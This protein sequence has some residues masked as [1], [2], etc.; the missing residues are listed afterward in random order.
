MHSSG[1]WIRDWKARHRARF[2]FAQCVVQGL[3]LRHMILALLWPAGKWATGLLDITTWYHHVVSS[4]GITTWCLLLGT[5][6]AVLFAIDRPD[7]SRETSRPTRRN[8]LFRKN[9][10]SSLQVVD[11]PTQLSVFF[12][13]KLREHNRKICY[14]T[15]GQSK[16]TTLIF[17]IYLVYT[18]NYKVG[19]VIVFCECNMRQAV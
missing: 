17:S 2:W 19:V 3:I 4:L 11:C 12:M 6:V 7:D 16:L 10:P 9:S 13:A 5:L 15:T 1:L 18:Y 14:F 8:G